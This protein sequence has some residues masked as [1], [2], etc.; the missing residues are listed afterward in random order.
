MHSTQSSDSPIWVPSPDRIRQA[1]L[2]R[3]ME[4]VGRRFERRFNSYAALHEWSVSNR[5]DF[6][7]SVWDFAA[8]R[9]ETR[10]T[11]TLVDGGDMLRSRWF[12][13]ARLN[14]AENLLRRRDDTPAII[15]RDEDERV[16]QLT[17]NA[18]YD[19]VARLS[20]AFR[21]WRVLPGD[22]IAAYVPNIPEA[23][24]GALAA[25]SVGAVWSSCSPDFGV[26]GVLDRFGQIEP[27]VLIG[28]DG[29]TYGGKR[30]DRLETLAEV[31]RGLPTL[32]RTLI[33]PHLDD[34]PDVTALPDGVL[35]DDVLSEN[36]AGPI[37]FAQLPF[38]HSLY[39]MY[40]SGTTGA[41]KCIVHAAGGT[42][43]QHLKEHQ[44]HC[45]VKPGDRVFYFTTCGWMMWNWLVS[46]L[47][48]NAA[49]VLY[50][51]NPF[52]PDGNVLFGIAEATGITHMGVS[53]KYIDALRTTGIRPQTA[54]DLQSVRVVLSTGSP[55]SPESFDFVY[56]D[57]KPDLHLASISG[58]TDILSCFV[59]GSPV[60]PVYR[61]EIQ[62]SGLG[63]AVD[64]FDTEGLSLR[65]QPGELVCT[66]SFPSMPVGFWNDPDGSRY[67]A[68][69][70]ERFPGIWCH[71]DWIER[72]VHNGFII[73]G[74]SDAVLNPGGVR[75]G[76]AEIYRCVEQIDDVVEA[77]CV[78]QEREG[79]VRV[80][81]F[82]RLKAGVM[83]NAGLRRRIADDLRSTYSPR[84]VPA[85]ILQVNDIPRT[86]SGKL[87]ELAVRNVIHGLPVSNQEAL[88]NP[89]ALA[90]F[91]NRPELAS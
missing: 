37:E 22:R 88:A 79:D 81:L 19:Y 65:G 14:F 12:P 39:I 11:R 66:A 57:V 7:N 44:L 61:G 69:Y 87:T 50:D 25:A 49:I 3:F 26:Q 36:P 35:W 40:S 21:E 63:M 62:V 64:V 23:V 75:I 91:E 45:D 60:D 77:I 73:H 48:S 82:V 83:L 18:L 24:I 30:F 90:E 1:N 10:G 54:H 76:T 58:G 9:A 32:E 6:W 56:R 27:R 59:G 20:R 15:F 8:V 16:R 67:R 52:T 41:P 29:Y 46:A 70:F 17:W 38:D 2:T 28:A 86:R 53:A 34:A 51:G 13:D 47:G 43:L 84:H 33:V 80:I 72:T 89:E 31:A 55:L 85:V 5:G 71:G 68:S 42:L 4:E 74:R 78:G